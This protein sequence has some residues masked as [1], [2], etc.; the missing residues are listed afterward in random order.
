MPSSLSEK[1]RAALVDIRDN[2]SS[3]AEFTDEGRRREER[4][5]DKKTFYA[6]TRAL[7][8]ISEATRKIPDDIEAG[9]PHID[10]RSI[11][12][13]G[14]FHRHSY[15][16]VEADLVQRTVERDL[17]VLAEM[18][19]AELATDDEPTPKDRSRS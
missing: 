7:E 19:E 6:V 9:H 13:A 2:I 11:R 18:I 1:V 12:D 15:D 10:W 4:G 8:I 5:F 3:V 17:P 16:R 14:N